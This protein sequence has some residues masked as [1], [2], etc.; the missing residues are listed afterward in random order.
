MQQL[1]VLLV[2]W[3][4]EKFSKNYNLPNIQRVAQE[5]KAV[6]IPLKDRE[7]LKQVYNVIQ[8][9]VILFFNEPWVIPGESDVREMSQH[10]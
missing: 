8:V 1:G 10:V 2:W 9:K 7:L 4:K 6:G 5:N 3:S